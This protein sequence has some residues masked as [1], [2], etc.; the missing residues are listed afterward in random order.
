MFSSVKNLS[1]VQQARNLFHLFVLEFKDIVYLEGHLK[2]VVS[3]RVTYVLL[4]D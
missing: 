3:C 1:V 4:L 2:N